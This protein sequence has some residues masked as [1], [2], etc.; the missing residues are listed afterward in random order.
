MSIVICLAFQ[1]PPTPVNDMHGYSEIAPIPKSCDSL[2]ISSDLF[3]TNEKF[4][5]R[6]THEKGCKFTKGVLTLICLT[7]VKA[8]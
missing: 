2:E 4:D 3:Q 5:Q 8:K 7:N 6:T 1:K